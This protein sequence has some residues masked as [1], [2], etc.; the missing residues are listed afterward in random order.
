[1]RR[2]ARQSNSSLFSSPVAANDYVCRL[3]SVLQGCAFPRPLPR[4]VGG[5]YRRAIASAV[6]AIVDRSSG[7]GLLW[8][9]SGGRLVELRRDWAVIEL[10]ENGS[11][12]I[13]DRRRLDVGSGR[14][15]S[16]LRPP[17]DGGPRG[18]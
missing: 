6:A 15:G 8:A 9:I 1:M 14:P 18:E 13:V 16:G 7:V 5:Y 11:Q 17:K 4:P 10:A 2:T 3:S 12:R